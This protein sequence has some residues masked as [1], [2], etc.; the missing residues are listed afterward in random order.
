MPARRLIYGL[1]V[2]F[3]TW[4]ALATRSHPTWFSWWLQ[5]YGGD[6]IWAGMFLFF[7]RIFFPR[8]SLLKLATINFCLGA[9]D[10]FSQLYQGEW[11]NSVRSTV[12]GRLL[13]GA[14]FLSSD[15]LCYAVGT[16]I[17]MLLIWLTEKYWLT[18]SVNAGGRNPEIV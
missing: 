13:F 11:A 14:G 9:L 2:A 1:A 17:A 10:E 5:Q 18:G 12:I 7:L 8:T 16:L 4:L 6:T 3:L 15:L